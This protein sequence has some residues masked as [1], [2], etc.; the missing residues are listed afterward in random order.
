MNLDTDQEIVTISRSSLFENTVFSVFADHIFDKNGH[1]VERYL[2]VVPK[3]LLQDSI[4]GV[5]VL[6]VDGDKVGLI[7]IFRHP[8]GRWSWEAIK[9]HVESGEEVISAAIRELSEEAGY[10]VSP[11]MLVDYGI[12]SPESGVIQA[13]I[14]LFVA[15]IIGK[16]RHKIEGEL[17][18][19]ELRFFNSGEIDTLIAN[20]QIE[21]ASTMVVLLKQRL[22]Q[23]TFITL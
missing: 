8:L 14:H 18:H 5:V 22:K 3:S 21:D 7:R 17:G 4:A 20:G 11:E 23:D 15:S 19:G 10:T 12:V 16:N 6:P 2:S 9:G 1:Q 13:R